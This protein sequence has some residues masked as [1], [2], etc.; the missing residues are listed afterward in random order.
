MKKINKI[1]LTPNDDKAIQS[2]DSVETFAYRTRK[3]LYV[4]NN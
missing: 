3:D 1:D 4:K 2:V